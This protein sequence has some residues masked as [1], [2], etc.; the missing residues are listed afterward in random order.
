MALLWR[1]FRPNMA[2]SNRYGCFSP[3]ATGASGSLNMAIGPIWLLNIWPLETYG[4][5][6]MQKNFSMAHPSGRHG[7]FNSMAPGAS[8]SLNMAIGP[9]WLLNIWPLETYGYLRM[10]K[11]FFY[12]ASYWQTWPF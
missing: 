11:K 2:P 5:L 1:F 4:Y 9:I 10:K 12:G 7:P 3:M 6:R 8:G